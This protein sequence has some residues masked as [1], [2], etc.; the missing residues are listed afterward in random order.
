MSDNFPT[1]IFPTPLCPTPV[2]RHDIFPTR[3]LPDM[4]LSRQ[5]T[6]GQLRVSLGSAQG[7]LRSV[8]GQFRVYHVGQMSCRENVVSGNRGRKK[9]ASGK[10]LSGNRIVTLLLCIIHITSICGNENTKTLQLLNI[11]R[12][13]SINPLLL[14][15]PVKFQDIQIKF[16]GI[17][18]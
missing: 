4:I 5:H 13:I 18:L 16:M 10:W 3:H 17:N 6:Q 15:D 1:V 14:L 12:T 9:G 11:K 2:A 7:Q 8:Q